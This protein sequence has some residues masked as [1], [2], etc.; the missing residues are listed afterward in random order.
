MFVLCPQRQRTE[1]DVNGYKTKPDPAFFYLC[2]LPDGAV[3]K[4][5]V[6]QSIETIWML[7]VIFRLLLSQLSV[8]LVSSNV[9]LEMSLAPGSQWFMLRDS[10]LCPG[11]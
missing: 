8:L 11:G 9:G 1:F 6:R 7:N 10:S 3:I 2:E 5:R 4:I